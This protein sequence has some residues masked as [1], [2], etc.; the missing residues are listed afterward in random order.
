MSH[1]IL[2]NLHELPS[3]FFPFL[4]KES[5]NSQTFFTEPAILETWWESHQKP[6]LNL[7]VLTDDDQQPIGFVP[8]CSFDQGK[9]L[10]LLGD[11]DVTDYSDIVVE[12]GKEAVAFTALEHFLTENS[13]WQKLQLVS[14]PEN[15]PTRQALLSMSQHNKWTFTEEQQDI[16]PVISLPTT[17]EEYL[18]QIGKKQRHEIT[19]KWK[20]LQE[21]GSVEFRV[22]TD[23]RQNLEVLETF[24]T[25]H[26]QSSIEKAQFWTQEHKQ[27]FELLSSAASEHGWLRLYFLDFNG[28]PAAAMYCF[29]YANQLM[30]YNSGFD[31]AAYADKSIG[32]VLTSFTIQDTIKLGKKH[33]NFLRGGEEYKFRYGAKPEAV[34]N[35]TITKSAS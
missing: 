29:D 32:N 26:K 28:K 30:V 17:W 35:L 16:C 2:Q 21:Q 9:T 7:V 25:L 3:A 18:A 6:K 27:Y 23:V 1:H 5:Q 11:Q 19:R 24:F 20:R 13:I 12:K 8:F 34:F 4:T 14:I 31:A 33:Y 15:S 10:Q 22:V